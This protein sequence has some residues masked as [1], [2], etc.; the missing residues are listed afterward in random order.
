LVC[1]TGLAGCA[2]SQDGG[3]YP[4]LVPL[5]PIAAQAGALSARDAAAAGQSLEARAADLRRRAAE[6]RALP[7]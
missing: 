2:S 4:R 7:L 3:D 1:L 6:L 5:G